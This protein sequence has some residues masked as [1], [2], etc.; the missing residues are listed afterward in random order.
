MQALLTI[1][2]VCDRLLVDRKTLRAISA[3]GELPRI[4]LGRRSIRYDPDDVAGHS[5]KGASSG[6]LQARARLLV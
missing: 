2:E 3:S 4:V 5:R 6:G 1:E